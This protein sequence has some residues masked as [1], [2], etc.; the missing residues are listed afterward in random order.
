MNNIYIYTDIYSILYMLYSTYIHRIYS[1][2][3]IYNSIETL[4]PVFHVKVFRVLSSQ[5]Q[6]THLKLCHMGCPSSAR[7][8]R[9]RATSK[10]PKG[11]AHLCLQP[12]RTWMPWPSL[13]CLCRGNVWP[14]MCQILWDNWAANSEQ[15]DLQDGNDEKVQEFQK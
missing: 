8:G 4:N 6:G 15:T 3:C 7:A 5:K 11:K 12:V 14:T 9:A 13:S 10:G 2:Q 1:V